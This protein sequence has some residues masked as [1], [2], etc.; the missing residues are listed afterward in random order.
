MAMNNTNGKISEQSRRK[1]AQALFAIME[2]YDY[3]EITVT[4]IAQEAGL[5]RKTFYRLFST[6]D[7]I[8]R[9]QSENWFSQI[10]E[11]VIEEQLHSYWDVVRCYFDFCEQNKDMLL[12]LKKHNV[13]SVF[14]EYIEDNAIKVFESVYSKEMAQKNSLLLP[15]LLSYSIGGVF[16]LLTK[17]IDNDMVIPAQ[18]LLQTL[19]VRYMSPKM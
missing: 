5:S 19:R 3:R 2:Q 15:Y 9:Y 4:Q 17:W 11:Q 8:L 18:E 12:L 13:I 6:K 1:M 10:Y 7:D 16:S 14:F